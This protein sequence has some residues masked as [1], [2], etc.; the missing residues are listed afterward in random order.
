MTLDAT[1]HTQQGHTG[2]EVHIGFEVHGESGTPVILI[3]G[4]TMTR[5][6]WANQVAGLRGGHRVAIFDNRGVGRSDRPAGKYTMALMAADTIGVMDALGW[7]KAHVVGV[8]MGGMIAQHL[9]LGHRNRVSS[10]SLIATIV[11]GMAGR[12]PTPNGMRQFVGATL[13]R[14]RKRLE[15]FQKLL[16]P[17]AFLRSAPKE[18]FE[19]AIWARLREIPDP[20][21]RKAQMGAIL[22][23]NTA[24]RLGELRGLPTLV[25][26]PQL[27]ILV[28]PAQVARLASLIPGARFEP[29]EGAGHGVIQQCPRQVNHLLLEHFDAVD[30]AERPLGGGG[31]A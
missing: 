23:H 28:R 17:E 14:G 31:P 25:I 3:M 6:A 4:Y 11:G 27:D 10:L 12:L 30:R 9:A 7:E 16:Y 21:T 29:I 15:S 8:S 20:H 2:G 18:W 13:G 1:P 22:G 26:S 19:S 5:S 24:S